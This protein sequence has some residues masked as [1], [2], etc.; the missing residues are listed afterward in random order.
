M[1]EDFEEGSEKFQ[2]SFGRIFLGLIED[3]LI[4]EYMYE[5]DPETPNSPMVFSPR[6]DERDQTLYEILN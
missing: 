1:A 3:L 2:H 6:S 4:H 5:N